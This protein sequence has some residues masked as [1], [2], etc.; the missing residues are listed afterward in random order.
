[1]P[2]DLTVEVAG[3]T[4]KNP[5]M[6]G[7]GEATMDLD[8]LRAAVDAGAGAVVAKSANES[9]AARAQL[10][11]AEYA[12]LD[13][14][15]RPLP[16]PSA[17]AGTSLFCRSGLVAEPF[18]RW[19]TTLATADEHAR[20]ADCVVVASVIVA[21]PDRAVELSRQVEA[22]G[23]RWLELNV[24]APHGSEAPAGA[25][26]STTAAEEVGRLVATV[27]R[28]VGLP[29]T[30]KL[31]GHR[32]GLDDVGAALDAGADAVCLAGRS[33]AFLPDLDT[34]R[35]VLGT[36]GAIGGSWALPT[37]LHWIAKAR[38]RF[39]PDAC[40]LGTNGARNGGDVARFLLAGARAVQMASA[41]LAAG[42]VAI[43][44]AVADLSAYLRTQGVDARALVGEAAD[45][46]Q[47]Y[48]Q[49]AEEHP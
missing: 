14:S 24:G 12:Y 27:R 42:P 47:S 23:L 8:G 1:M 43:T 40:L 3:L 34:R 22:A 15:W 45:H 11:A 25:I 48:R 6:V 26:A 39:G 21:D 31:G 49:R 5:V 41:V 36:F 29:L 16:G 37:S 13:A 17:D 10:A 2:A 33:L 44:E 32:S 20:R 18:D 9:E 35:P 4:L 46:V 30:V 19:M 7:S 28:A 38:G